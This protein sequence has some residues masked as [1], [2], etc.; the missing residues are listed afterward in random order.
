[1]N[2]VLVGALSVASPLFAVGMYKLQAR[3][4]RWDAQRHAED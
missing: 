4:E 1:M 3:L 2:P